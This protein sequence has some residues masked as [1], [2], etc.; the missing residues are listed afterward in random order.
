MGCFILKKLRAFCSVTTVLLAIAFISVVIVTA[1]TVTQTDDLQLEPVAARSSPMTSQSATTVLPAT[2]TAP[3]KVVY[4][5]FDDGPDPTNTP[6]ILDILKSYNVPA[7]F[8]V[9]GTQVEASPQVLQRIR[10]EGHAIGNHTYNHRYKEL[11]QS[12]DAY[13]AQLRKTDALVHDAVG[14]RPE[15]SRAPGGTTGNFT[16]AY[17]TL[18]EHEGYREVGWNISS[19]DASSARSAQIINNVIQQAQ[20]K[21][22]WPRAIVLMHD[23]IGHLETVTALPQII[24]YFLREGFEFRIVDRSTPSPW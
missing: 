11:Y 22:L 18:L 23:G 17:W 16:T 10:D 24:E 13:I 7:T 2:N 21:H 15:I 5:T 9:I 14:A 20:Q 4:L 6:Q 12:S 19:G 1:T 8:F 3:H